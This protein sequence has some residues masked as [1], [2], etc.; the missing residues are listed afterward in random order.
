MH[1]FSIPPSLP[2]SPCVHVCVHV[3]T[4]VCAG[5]WKVSLKFPS[6]R[7][8]HL[9][10]SLRQGL[11]LAWSKANWLSIPRDLLVFTSPVLRLDAPHHDAQLFFM[12]WVLEIELLSLCLYKTNKNRT[13][14]TNWPS[15]KPS[16]HW[17]VCEASSVCS[18]LSIYLGQ[19]ACAPVFK[20]IQNW[21]SPLGWTDK[22]SIPFKDRICCDACLAALQSK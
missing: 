15:S 12:M 7:H 16:L 18:V 17:L 2:S 3:N 22:S 4:L 11:S 10:F 1:I 14:F 21:I 20:C 19:W 5:I 13:H 6:T 8:T 9:V